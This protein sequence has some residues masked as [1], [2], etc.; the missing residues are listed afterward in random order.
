MNY[1]LETKDHA[2][3]GKMVVASVK[4]SQ[5]D[6]DNFRKSNQARE[7]MRS[8]LVQ[9]LVDYMLENNMVEVTTMREAYRADSLEDM[10]RIVARCCLVKD[11]HIKVLR[12]YG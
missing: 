5:F 9:Q 3:G 7:H 11:E 12:T 1:K 10:H 6:M 4:V 8:L 2:I